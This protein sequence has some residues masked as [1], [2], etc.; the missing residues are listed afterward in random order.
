MINLNKRGLSSVYIA[1][2]AMLAAFVAIYYGYHIYTTPK[3]GC[4]ENHLLS[5]A[6][7][8]YIQE[9]SQGTNIICGENP[10][11]EKECLAVSIDVTTSEIDGNPK[12]ITI[13]NICEWK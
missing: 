11:T 10:K 12:D 9:H 13:K 5:Q 2:I 8:Q 4:T 1:T 6:Q 7:I 3:Q